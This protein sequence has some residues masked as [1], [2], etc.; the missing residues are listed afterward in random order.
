MPT[1]P[2]PFCST[3]DF[4]HPFPPDR[5]GECL[6]RVEIALQRGNR[7]EANAAIA[8]L[9]E[10]AKITAADG[11]TPDSF[12]SELIDETD[13]NALPMRIVNTLERH[14][15]HR[16]RQLVKCSPADLLEISSFAERA[17]DHIEAALA[18]H[19]LNLARSRES[20]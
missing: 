10:Q 20:V 7:D 16:V 8:R 15:I 13:R 3:P 17:V 18:K 12:V 5:I 11:I 1:A 9:F 2:Y 4:Q 19:G 6:A 14:G